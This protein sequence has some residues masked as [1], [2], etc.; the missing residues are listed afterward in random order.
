MVQ[1]TFSEPPESTLGT[2]NL[3]ALGHLGVFPTNTTPSFLTAVQ[4]QTQ[5]LS[6]ARR[7]L[8][9]HSHPTKGPSSESREQ[10]HVTPPPSPSNWNPYSMLPGSSDLNAF[11]GYRQLFWRMSL[12]VGLV[13]VFI[14]L[15]FCILGWNS[16]DGRL[17]SSL[18]IL[19][20]GGRFQFVPSS[21]G[22]LAWVTWWRWFLPGFLLP[23]NSLLLIRVLWGGTF[24]LNI[25]SC[26][27]VFI[28]CINI[29]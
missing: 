18:C 15:R 20:D 22:L 3:L 13:F 14:W 11:I 16:T 21:P 25:Y 9:T 7:C 26:Q 2:W 24:G 5:K 19:A 8:Q 10:C 28:F 29:G 23:V 17:S 27:T 12:C 4:P 1:N 6:T